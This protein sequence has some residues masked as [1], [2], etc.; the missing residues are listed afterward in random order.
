MSF[1]ENKPASL[2]DV[3]DLKVKGKETLL[4]H[5]GTVNADYYALYF[6]PDALMYLNYLAIYQGHWT[7]EQLDLIGTPSSQV[8]RRAVSTDTYQSNTNSYTF[9]NMDA[10]KIYS[11]RLRAIGENGQYSGWSEEKTLTFGTTGI[12]SISTKIATDNTVRYFDLQ[13]REISPE[14]KGLLIRKQGNEVKKVVK[15]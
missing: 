14:T 7:A 13:G 11:Y 12:Q 8:S 3:Q 1:N 6:L 4:F 15:Q 5:F 2:A 10:G 9:S